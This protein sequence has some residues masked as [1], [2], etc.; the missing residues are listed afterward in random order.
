MST[1]TKSFDY[2][3]SLDPTWDA[4]S[5]RGGGVIAGADAVIAK[6]CERAASE[7]GEHEVLGRPR[8]LVRP[9]DDAAPAVA[10]RIPGRVEGDRVVEGLRQGGHVRNLDGPRCPVRD[11]R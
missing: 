10:P 7:P 8:R 9:G 11:L 4:R 5:D 2:A 1:R 3:V 6:A